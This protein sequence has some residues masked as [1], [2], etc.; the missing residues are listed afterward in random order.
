MHLAREWEAIAAAE[1]KK[2]R[3][4]L[5]LQEIGVLLRDMLEASPANI[6]IPDPY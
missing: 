4:L 6:P 2:E 3:S 5:I 1:R